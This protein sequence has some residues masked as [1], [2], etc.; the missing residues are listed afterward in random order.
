MSEIFEGEVQPQNQLYRLLSLDGEVGGAVNMAIDASA[1]K[2]FEY[3]SPEAVRTVAHRLTIIYYG[4]TLRSNLF[5]GLAALTNGIKFETI[6]A[7]GE[8]LIDY[9]NGFTIQRDGDWGL[10]AGVDQAFS[11]TTGNVER[12]AVRWTLAR[13]GRP[14]WLAPFQRFRATIQ[15]NLAALSEGP[16]RMQ[17]QGSVYNSAT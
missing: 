11:A 7:V 2:R 8:V 17:L 14:L 4:T 10:L 15:D 6:G 9:T 16:F 3:A 5:G 12:V 1:Q 13:A